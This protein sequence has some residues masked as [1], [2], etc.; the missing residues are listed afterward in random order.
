MWYRCHIFFINDA[1]IIIAKKERIVVNETL[2]IIVADDNACMSDFINRIIENDN[3]FEFIGSAKDEKD[4]IELI[5]TLK[6]SIVI[7]DLKKV[8]DG[9]E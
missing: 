1:N 3:R 4:E 6:P 5:N 7:T 9:Q 8:I 2:T